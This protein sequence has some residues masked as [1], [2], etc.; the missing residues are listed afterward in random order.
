[1]TKISNIL[2]KC[3]VPSLSLVI[4]VLYFLGT[5]KVPNPQAT[6]IL[7]RPL[8]LIIIFTSILSLTGEIK[9]EKYKKTKNNYIKFDFKLIKKQVLFLILFLGYAMFYNSLGYL[10]SSF[11]LLS[12]AII[13]LEGDWKIAFVISFFL[14]LTVFIV[15]VKFLQISLPWGIL[16][17]FQ[18]LLY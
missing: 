6:F 1:M 9:D 3:L 16:L 10:I 15:F 11:L 8:A 4:V 18:P 17:Q 7:I 14:S 5:K 12:S 2:M 13:I